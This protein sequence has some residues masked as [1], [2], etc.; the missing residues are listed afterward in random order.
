[1]CA[2]IFRCEILLGDLQSEEG[3]DIVL[4]LILPALEASEQACVLKATLTYFN[5]IRSAMQV[6]SCELVLNRSGTCYMC[7]EYM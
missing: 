6:A 5:V 1:M 7:T 3:R 4:T 2:N